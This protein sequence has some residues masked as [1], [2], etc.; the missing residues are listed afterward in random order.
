MFR[1][2]GIRVFVLLDRI[3]RFIYQAT[4]GRIGEVQGS[5]RMLLLHSV[6]RKTGK[7]R[8]HC[9]QYQRDGENYLV[10]ASNFGLPKPPAWYLNLMAHPHIKIQVGRQRLWPVVS[11]KHPPYAKYQAATM[12]EIPIVVLTPVA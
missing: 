11:K 9:L 6:G 8:T 7:I 4:D 2:I 5:V 10:V 3:S 1:Q 12:R